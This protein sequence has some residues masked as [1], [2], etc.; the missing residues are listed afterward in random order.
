MA[1]GKGKKEITNLTRAGTR[2]KINQWGGGEAERT[3]KEKRDKDRAWR[4][5]RTSVTEKRA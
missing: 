2:G 3:T 1:K 5:G 4:R